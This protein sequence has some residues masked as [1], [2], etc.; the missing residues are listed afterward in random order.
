MTVREILDQLSMIYGQ[1]TPATMELNDVVFCSQYFAADAP[2]VLFHCIENCTKI[3]ILS[4]N[5]Y[6]D[7]QLINTAI[8]LLLTTG[9]YQWP[10]EEWD[11]LLPATQI[12]IPLQALI[13]EA[14]QHRLN[15]MVPT[16]GHHG[17]APAHPYLS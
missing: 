12:W 14:F 9:L 7:C 4:Q 16:V 17:Y 13:Q 10:F 15:A 3:A 2:E 5:P 8:R 6:T 11:R 1:P